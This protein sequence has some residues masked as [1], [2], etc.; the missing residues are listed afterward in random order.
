MR[1]SG[2][3]A[4]VVLFAGL[5][6][7]VLLGLVSIHVPFGRDQGVSAYVAE[8]MARG[9]Y[10]Y[11]D[12]YHF[13]LPA[14]FFTYRL[15]SFLPL[16]RV[17]S[18][19]LLHVIF[20]SLTYL[21]V[22]AS[23]RKISG[24]LTSAFAAVFYCAFAVVIYTSYWNI[25]QKESLACLPIIL[26]LFFILR[27]ISS[28]D[29][30]GNGKYVVNLFIAGVF[31]GISAQYKPTLGIILF[32]AFYPAILNIKEMKKA[33]LMVLSPGIGFSVS[34]IPLLIYLF[35]TDTLGIML[36]SVFKF[37]G[38]Y[39][40]QAYSGFSK[41]IM[42]TFW[43]VL[44][45]LYDWRFLSVLALAGIAAYIRK[46]KKI[47]LVT[48]F[49]ALLLVQLIIQM[50]FFTYHWIPLLLPVSILAAT[51][52]GY[53]IGLA[54][55][56]GDESNKRL[57]SA[58]LVL[59]LIALLAGCLAPAANRYRREWLYNT[60]QIEMNTFLRPHGQ[61]ASGDICQ[62]AQHA[63][64]DYIKN[65]TSESD[66]VLVFGHEL[67]LYLLMERYPD[68]RFAYDQP[69]NTDPKGNEKFSVFRDHL[70][71]EFMNDLIK[72]PPVYIIIIENDETSIEP[73]DSYTQMKNFEK[74]S[75]FI[76]KSYKLETKIE[77]YYIYR[78]GP[79]DKS[80]VENER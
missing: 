59:L 42:D 50:K 28:S 38:F 23:A 25:A 73:D 34:F 79:A 15:A 33:V 40:G 10:P 54:G 47:K 74:F 1:E 12:I 3:T 30:S 52:A 69:L 19:N 44:R 13:N 62:M 71:A 2:K 76:D 29:D 49:G 48:I 64:A 43:S 26:S 22:Y 80:G 75:D 18:V 67:G 46:D 58:I 20:V 6:V 7:T 9:G 39:G 45:W 55:P 31:A 61:W 36:E 70:R 78:Y 56:S 65:K 51:G 11:K 63:V 35:S 57:Q 24:P 53:L 16:P 60:G 32:A 4:G 14:I 77:D 41:N 8:I 27:S 5:F 72:S 68:T 21:G 17:E 37:G 66:S